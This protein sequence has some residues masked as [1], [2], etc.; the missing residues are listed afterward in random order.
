MGVV[1]IVVDGVE[2]DVGGVVVGMNCWCL[3]IGVGGG[4]GGDAYDCL[5]WCW[6]WCVLN[7]K[8]LN[9][10]VLNINEICDRMS[11]DESVRF[12]VFVVAA[13]L[14]E[15]ERLRVYIFFSVV[16]VYRELFM[17]LM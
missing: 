15:N 5:W 10:K 3:R 1:D 8:V 9:I 2:G 14:F 7:I 4:C 17:V 16:G 12:L 13:R 6:Y 11:L